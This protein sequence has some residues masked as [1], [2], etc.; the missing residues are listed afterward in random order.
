MGNEPASF[1][2]HAKT[3]DPVVLS[4]PASVSPTL[5]DVVLVISTGFAILFP[6]QIFSQPHHTVFQILLFR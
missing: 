6:D 4:T 3:L 1:A 5:T 2:P